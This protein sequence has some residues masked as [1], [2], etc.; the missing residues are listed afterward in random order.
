MKHGMDYSG[1]D[2]G[3][4]KTTDLDHNPNPSSRGGP[5]NAPCGPYGPEMGYP[6]MGGMH[7]DVNAKGKNGWSGPFK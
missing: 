6:G 1:A 5:N 2:S 3:G 7:G 4:G